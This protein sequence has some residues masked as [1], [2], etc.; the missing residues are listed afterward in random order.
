M[1]R[2]TRIFL[3][4]TLASTMATVATA[5]PFK[6]SA[7]DQVQLGQKVAAQIRKEEKV[8]PD[9]DARVKFIR[10]VG[11][12]L[13]AADAGDTKAPWQFTF[14]VI[15]S[16]EVNAFA[17]PGGPVFF[18]TGLL[19]KMETEDQVAAVMGHELVHVRKEHWANQ[20]AKAQRESLVLNIGLI[21]LKANNTIANISNLGREVFNDLR[22]SRNAETEADDIGMQTMIKAGFNPNGMADTFRILQSVSGGKGWEFLSSHPDDAKRVKRVEENIKKQGKTFPPQKKLNLPKTKYKEDPALDSIA[23]GFLSAITLRG[24]SGQR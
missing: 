7:K 12:K 1:M 21:L 11:A 13:L 4:V 23:E 5:D 9:N 24:M 16:K 6:P 22:Y 2:A 15:E 10:Q 3:S 8:L 18:Y 19:D 14:D 20:Y 17:L